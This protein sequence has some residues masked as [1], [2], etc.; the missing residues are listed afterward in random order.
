M[1]GLYK[2]LST[3]Q[4]YNREVEETAVN[5]IPLFNYPNHYG[6]HIKIHR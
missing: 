2:N 1:V 6:R 4:S 3:T 5:T